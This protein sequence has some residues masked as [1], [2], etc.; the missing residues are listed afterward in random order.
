MNLVL[1]HL[2]NDALPAYF[3]DTLKQFKHFHKGQIYTVL[4]A[5][6]NNNKLLK[7]WDCIFI[8]EAKIRQTERN[9]RFKRHSSFFNR[10][11]GSRSASFWVYSTQR[12]IV[13]EEVMRMYSLNN[14]IHAEYDNTVYVHLDTLEFIL[15]K[16]YRNKVAMCPVRNSHLSAGFMYVSNLSAIQS[17]NDIILN[18]LE[19]GETCAS[20]KIGYNFVCDMTMLDYIYRTSKLIELL[21]INPSGNYSN[22]FDEINAIFDGASWGQYIC[23]WD[24]VHKKQPGHIEDTSFIKPYIDKINVIWEIEAG[25]RMPYMIYE[26]KKIKFVNLHVHS[27]RILENV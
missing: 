24:P 15:D 8:D 20:Q 13:L 5:S 25:H 7:Q 3:W 22:H 16:H 19:I 21:P 10:Y 26:N 23:G 1:I 2:G 17:V 12:L 27:K 18:L 9:Q 11:A 14:T 6:Y 4:P